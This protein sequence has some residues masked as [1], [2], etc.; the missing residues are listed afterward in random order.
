MKKWILLACVASLGVSSTYSYAQ[1]RGVSESP[2]ERAAN[3]YIV[4]LAE[5]LS[6]QDVRG[7]ARRAAA[8]F[9][10]V[11]ARIYDGS[12]GGFAIRLN[13]LNASRLL[14]DTSLD[15]ISVTRDRVVQL[16]PIAN[17]PIIRGK[18]ENK[19]SKSGVDEEASVG[20]N[21]VVPWGVERV[22]SMTTD[23]HGCESDP[24]NKYTDLSLRVCILDTGIDMDHPDL[25]IGGGVS[26]QYRE[27]GP[28]DNHGHGS[29]VAGTIGAIK[30]QQGVIG[31]APGV[32]VY[33]IKVL[34]RRGSGILSD[35]IAG[36][37][38]SRD[39]GCN[40]ANLSLGA[41]TTSA[42]MDELAVAVRNSAGEGVIFTLA[43]GNSSAD[44]NYY[45][46][47]KASWTDDDDQGKTGDHVVTIAAIDITDRF[48]SFSNFQGFTGRA[49]VDFAQPGVSVLSTYKNGGY[50]TMS[51]TSMAAPHAA[52]LIAE[53]LRS[54]NSLYKLDGCARSDAL[55]GAGP[56]NIMVAPDVDDGSGGC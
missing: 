44:T 6:P 2:E 34:N 50:A 1:E 22:T 23:S 4:R 48:A 13:S 5:N 7:N 51:G 36:I 42:E 41:A 15:V 18:P 31:V 14:N 56:Y 26:Y 37:D 11:L 10:G 19:P 27:S 32:E 20:C 40:I 53:Y 21:E 39:L 8:R 17:G 16:P 52:G 12:Y 33:A 43:A 3:T 46:P 35:V 45:T 54:G 28:D 30:N 24:A 9:N 47:A 38:A 49:D 29:H 25:N 55:P